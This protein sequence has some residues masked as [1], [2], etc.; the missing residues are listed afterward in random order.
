MPEI[1]ERME[2][3]RE[4]SRVRRLIF[5]RAVDLEARYPG[6]GYLPRHVRAYL[7]RQ[8]LKRRPPEEVPDA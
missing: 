3:L 8:S 4:R 2:T 1:E 6:F 5:R 7:V